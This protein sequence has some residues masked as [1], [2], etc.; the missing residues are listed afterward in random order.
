MLVTVA[1]YRQLTSDT[2]TPDAD[3]ELALTDAQRLIEE[4][5]RR[6]LESAQRTET[7][8]RYGMRI[9]PTATPVTVAEG[10]T[11]SG[12]VAL[13]DT[14]PVWNTWG[15]GNVS[16]AT[17]TYVGGYTADTLPVE[18]AAAIAATAQD[19]VRGSQS[20]AP[21]GATSVALGDARVTYDRP[22]GGSAAGLPPA[23]ADS[24]AKYKRRYL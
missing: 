17:V 14:S 16:E 1:R 10:F 20:A 3:L 5:L 2:T 9:Y 12:G 18:L 24:I 19:R 23:L 13:L 11:I 7:L 15:G 8:R 6:P 22:A 4:H 21:Y